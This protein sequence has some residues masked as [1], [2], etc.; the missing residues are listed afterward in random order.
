M[1]G[2]C[3]KAAASKFW[4]YGIGTSA[5]VMRSGAAS[6]SSKHSS[7][8]VAVISDPIPHCGH[9]SSTVT[10]LCVL[11]TDLTM[12]SLSNGFKDRRLSTCSA[13]T[14]L[15][16]SA[17]ILRAIKCVIT[18]ARCA[19]PLPN[20]VHALNLGSIVQSCFASTKP[21]HTQRHMCTARL[22]VRAPRAMLY[23]CAI[24]VA[25]YLTA[26]TLLLQLLRCLQ[27]VSHH[28]SVTN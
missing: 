14:S 16:S 9:P 1:S 26:D 27:V 11:R 22:A 7:F 24:N 19:R 13:Q 21:R 4:A 10:T 20:A 25:A 17:V 6:R 15:L 18:T 28:L 23:P 12:V 5:P 3:G 8:T 2:I